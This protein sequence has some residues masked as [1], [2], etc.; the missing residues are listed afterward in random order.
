MNIS[1]QNAESTIKSQELEGVYLSNTDKKTILSFANGEI[2]EQKAIQL[3]LQT[4]H[5]VEEK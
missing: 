3:I 1:L 5:T 2:S 4:P